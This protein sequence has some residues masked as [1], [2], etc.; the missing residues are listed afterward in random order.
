MTNSSNALPAPDAFASI[1]ALPTIAFD[2]PDEHH[3]R[4]ATFVVFDVN[5]EYAR[6]LTPLANGNGIGVSHV[7]LDG[8]AA[9]GHF[10]LPH[11]QIWQ[12]FS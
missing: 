5:G 10:R 4:G 1:V 12:N 2:K 3:A 11:L 8:T 9:A 7:V 6:A